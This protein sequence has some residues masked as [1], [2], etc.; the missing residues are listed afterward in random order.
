M[1]E[2]EKGLLAACEK[3]KEPG[4]HLMFFIQN[5]HAAALVKRRE[6]ESLGGS[7][8]ASRE[9]AARIALFIPPQPGWGDNFAKKNEMRSVCMCERNCSRQRHQIS[10][11]STAPCFCSPDE[12]PRQCVSSPLRAV[13]TC[14]CWLVAHYVREKSCI[15]ARNAVHCCFKRRRRNSSAWD[16][17]VCGLKRIKSWFMDREL[18]RFR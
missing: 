11:H 12:A 13:C 18:W 14:D 16:I 5:A 7:S 6:L 8:V 9:H 4:A 15:P 10:T 1:K 17:A 3:T 2:A